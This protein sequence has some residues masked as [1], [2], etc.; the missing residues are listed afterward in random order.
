MKKIILFFSVLF[1]SVLF[2]CAVLSFTVTAE[3][4]AQPNVSAELPT[5]KPDASAELP[6]PKPNGASTELPTRRRGTRTPRNRSTL[7]SG[8]FGTE[9]PAVPDASSTLLGG[10]VPAIWE[11]KRSTLEID[12]EDIP[13]L[14]EHNTIAPPVPGKVIRYATQLMQHYDSNMDGILQEEEWKKLPGAPQAI[15]IDGDREITMEEL[16][17]FIAIY[18]QGRTIHHPQP[19]ERYF[20]PKQIASQFQIFKP[21]SPP[22]PTQSVAVDSEK[23]NV[24][25]TEANQA[26]INQTN[27]NQANVNQANANLATDITEEAMKEDETPIDDE[28]YAEIIAN[29]LAPTVRK[30]VTPP[31][32]LRGVPVWFLI[33]DQDGDGQV[34]LKE[35]APTLSVPALRI[36]GRLDKNGDGFITPDEVRNSE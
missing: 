19:V 3:D 27:T 18:G 15:D 13:D 35:F 2:F 26:N 22:I 14:L 32:S 28:V 24:N 5:P 9:N 8:I 21:I 16:I 10:T 20:Q 4:A 29:R 25:Q 30:Y 23:M 17:R 6:T 33:R 11:I 1:F 12:N 34:S 36:F 31:E 7:P